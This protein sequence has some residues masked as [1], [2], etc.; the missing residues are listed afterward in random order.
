VRGEFEHSSIQPT[1]SL[2]SRLN[3]RGTGHHCLY[4]SASTFKKEPSGIVHNPVRRKQIQSAV[5]SIND[6][7]IY[8]RV[9]G[10]QK[11]QPLTPANTHN[12]KALHSN[13]MANK[14]D[15][16]PMSDGHKAALAQGRHESRVVREY[17][18]ALK[19]TKP[20]RGRKRTAESIQERLDKIESEISVADP[21]NELLLL[22]ER[23]DL[24][25]E[26]QAL[27][28][29]ADI[30]SAETEFVKIA[31]TYSNRRH[32]SYATWREIGV[33]AAVLKKAGIPRS[34]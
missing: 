31:L 14:S 30:S 32:I 29:G 9:D 16:S 26:F 10:T 7:A 15:N 22:Q 21:L 19:S 2:N 3:R 13:F 23:R 11:K 24:Q 28:S 27:G 1:F 5:F 25:E 18:E 34:L 8:S 33:E 17:L 4:I 6:S 20:K 12:G